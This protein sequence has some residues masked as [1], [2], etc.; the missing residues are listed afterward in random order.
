MMEQVI[1]APPAMHMITLSDGCLET[2]RYWQTLPT[3]GCAEAGK[4]G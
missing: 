1:P 3:D 4:L 2:S